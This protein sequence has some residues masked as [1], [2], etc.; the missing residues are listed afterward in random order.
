MKTHSQPQA[1]DARAL[2]IA[3]WVNAHVEQIA[4]ES[5]HLIWEEVAAYRGTPLFEDVVHHVGEI[6]E[7]FTSTVLQGR[8]PQAADSPF[9]SGH[10][11]L[12]VEHGISLVDFL[13]AFRIAPVSYTHPVVYKSQAHASP[14]RTINTLWGIPLAYVVTEQCIRCKYMDC[15]EVCP[16]DCFYEGE[17]MLVINPNE[18]IDCGVCEP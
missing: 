16:V 17:N 9:T 18:C 13:K 14:G 4:R 1:L 6:F 12:R 8:S 2:D 15:V 3:H 11:T 7:V 10:A 5:T